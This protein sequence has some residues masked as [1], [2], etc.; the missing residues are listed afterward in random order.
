MRADQHDRQHRP[1]RADDPDDRRDDG[2]RKAGDLDQLAKQRAEQED[3]EIVFDE[4]DHAFHENA[5]E[6]GGNGGG[7]G[8]EDSAHRG[9]G[10]EQDHGKS[11]IGDEHEEAKRSQGDQ[12]IHGSF[13]PA[14]IHAG[15]GCFRRPCR[16]ICKPFFSFSDASERKPDSFFCRDQAR[17]WPLRR[18]APRHRES[19]RMLSTNQHRTGMLG[20]VHRVRWSKRLA[21]EPADRRTKAH[22]ARS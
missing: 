5:A 1:F 12:K 11:A 8:E 20:D 16:F 18:P 21:L 4:P 6:S 13:L 9:D 3:R 14:G 15:A 10:S 22:N 19:R 2:F 7:I 17:A